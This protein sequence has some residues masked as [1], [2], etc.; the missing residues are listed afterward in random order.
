MT[1]AALDPASGQEPRLVIVTGMSGAGRSTASHVLEDEGWFVVDN[2][3]PQLLGPLAELSMSSGDSL[4]RLAAVVDVRSRAFFVALTDT[5][6]AVRAKGLD[7]AV[8]YL[9][10]DDATLVRRFESVRRPHPLQPPGTL[11]DAIGQERALLADLRAAADILIDSSEMNVHQ[12]AA[13]VRAALGGEAGATGSVALT[14]MSFGFKNGIPLDAE[15]VADVRFLPNPHWVPQLRPKNGLDPEVAAYVFDAPGAT[16]FL[17]A[18][19]S[20]LQVVTRGYLA[21]GKRFAVAAVGCTG[22]KHRSVAMAE[23]L[24]QRLTGGGVRAT[25]AH[26]DLGRE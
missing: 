22:G 16:E 21:D 20:Y 12:L 1:A 9:E 17:D 26:R 5:L 24:A 18:Y 14:V 3:P 6:D 19:A 11:V 15:N 10:A 25:A 23:R 2:L 4:P 7:T 13:K 8:M